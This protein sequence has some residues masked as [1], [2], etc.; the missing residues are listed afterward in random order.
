MRGEA[1]AGSSGRVAESVLCQLRHV[2]DG[3]IPATCADTLD[4]MRPRLAPATV[5]PYFIVVAV[6]HAVAVATRFDLLAAKLPAALPTAIMI[7]QFPLIVLSGYFEGRVDHG[8]SMD[9]FPLW[10]RIKSRPVKLAFTFGF[11]YIACVALQTLHFSIGPI[12][13]TPPESFPPA[14]RAL[15]FAMF[16]AGM[17]FP[18]Y[19]AATSL[20]IPVL[21][22]I[23]IPLRTLPTLLGGILA[24][25]AGGGIG[26]GVFAVATRTQ[27]PAFV[28]SIQAAIHA[29]PAVALGVTLGMTF[30]PMILGWLLGKNDG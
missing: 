22:A 30:G 8:P 5:A 9:G 12:N 16:T 6:I 3:G 13:P 4:P 1:L 21:R 18:F 28:D 23:T 7:A 24:L 11:I 14:Q 20:L 10:M 2:S 17:F 25:A 27:L 29:S 26:I 19:L 15:W